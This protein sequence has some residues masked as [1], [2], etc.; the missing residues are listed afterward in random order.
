MKNEIEYENCLNQTERKIY[1]CLDL[2]ARYITKPIKYWVCRNCARK[3][4]NEQ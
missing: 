4:L 2:P 1:T 3:L